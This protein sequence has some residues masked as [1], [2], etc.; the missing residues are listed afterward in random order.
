MYRSILTVLSLLI[1]S[2]RITPQVQ[3]CK[4]SITGSV[5]DLETREPI[6]ACNIILQTLDGKS[7]GGTE[8]DRLGQFRFRNVQPGQYRLRIAYIGYQSQTIAPV[9][10][11]PD[12]TRNLDIQMD[13]YFGLSAEQAWED[14][15]KGIVRIYIW[16]GFPFYR[17]E[18]IELAQKYHFEIA[19]TGCSVMYTSRYDSIMIEYLE[20]ANGKGWFKKFQKEWDKLK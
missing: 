20:N 11:F 12:S 3:N 17:K 19:T 4:S 18:Q 8:S 15:H 10:V 2:T 16:A 7:I 9:V 5:V 6:I 14:I 1:V 13:P